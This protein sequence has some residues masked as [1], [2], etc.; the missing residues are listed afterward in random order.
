MSTY[1]LPKEIFWVTKLLWIDISI[2][3]IVVF[4][5]L[6]TSSFSNEEILIRLLTLSVKV[7]VWVVVIIGINYFLK[8]SNKWV[9]MF[10]IIIASSIVIS[11]IFAINSASQDVFLINKVLYFLQILIAS[12][13]IYLLVQQRSFFNKL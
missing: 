2:R 3:L 11:N 13:V 4:F 1:E 9:M 8:K 5:I 7:I 12:F 6:L 10:L